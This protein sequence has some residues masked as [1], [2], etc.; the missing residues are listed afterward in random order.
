MKYGPQYTKIKCFCY[1]QEDF[2]KEVIQ[3]LDLKE[4]NG[5]D[6]RQEGGRTVKVYHAL[7]LWDSNQ[8]TYYMCCAKSLTCV[9]CFAV[10]QTVTCFSVYGILQARILERVAMPSS[11]GSSQPRDL[12]H[13]SCFLHWQANSLPPAPPGKFIF[14]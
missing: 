12:I 5:C 6:R 10:L 4:K 11:W 3:E 9:Q 1:R 8:D 7:I 14:I 2:R 13:I